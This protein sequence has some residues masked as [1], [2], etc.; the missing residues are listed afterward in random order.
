MRL[1]KML[2]DARSSRSEMVAPDEV[3][4]DA[5]INNQQMSIVRSTNLSLILKR[6]HE[7]TSWKAKPQD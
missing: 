2:I 7:L 3:I 1:N 4:D 6:K 5:D